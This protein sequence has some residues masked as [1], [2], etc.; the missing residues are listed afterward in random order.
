[1]TN[2]TDVPQARSE[3]VL[4]AQ[5]VLSG[6]CGIVEGARQ[7]SGLAHRLAAEHDPDF[8]FFIGVDSETDHLPL[9]DVRQRWAEDALRNKDEELRSLEGFFRADAL[10]ACQSLILKFGRPSA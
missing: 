6:G 10:N 8:T 7:L 4:I 5:R 9:G 3:V 1:M 2:Q